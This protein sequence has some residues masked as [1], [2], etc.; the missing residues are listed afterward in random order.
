MPFGD[1]TWL[2]DL[3]DN[4]GPE[5]YE[6]RAEVIRLDPAASA[7]DIFVCK[8]DARPSRAAEEQDHDDRPLRCPWV[9]P[10]ESK[11]LHK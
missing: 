4:R 6:T 3:S 8:M 11:G 7:N 1:A 9:I 10:P 2:R 5:A